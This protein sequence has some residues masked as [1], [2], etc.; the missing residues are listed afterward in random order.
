MGRIADRV[1]TLWGGGR[2]AFW[3]SEPA[4]WAGILADASFTPDATSRSWCV[5]AAPNNSPA[6]VSHIV[7]PHGD[8][9]VPVATILASGIKEP[10]DLILVGVKSYSLDEAMDQFAPAVGPNTMILPLLN[11]MGHLDR[12]SAQFGARQI[13]GGMANISAGMD[14]EGRIVQFIPNHDLVFGEIPGGPS[15]RTRKVAACFDG[16]GFD[17]RASDVVMQD[18]WEKLVNSVWH[19]D[20]L[21]DAR[22]YWRHS[23]GTGRSRGDVRNLRRVLRCRYRLRFQTQ[24]RLYRVRHDPDHHSRIAVE[25]VNAARHR[26]GCTTEGEHILGD[27]VARASA[28]GIETPILNLAR[29]HVAASEIGRKRAAAAT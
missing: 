10:F 1:P 26:A 28:L 9:T 18:M 14:A 11:G 15:E 17:G 5:R 23:C 8:F 29:T 12:L 21:S 20:H 24:A 13:L 3:C 22:Q 27:M 2:C 19:R 4:P 7:S 25:V 6:S 16:A